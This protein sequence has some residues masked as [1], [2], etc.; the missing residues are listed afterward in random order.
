VDAKDHY[1]RLHS[2]DVTRHA[3]MLADALGLDEGDRRTLAVAGPLHDV[4]KIAMPDRVLRKPTKLTDEEYQIIKTHV[5]Y[6]VAIVRGVLD[7]PAVL[8]VIAHH[9][10]RHDGLGYP[11]GRRGDQTPLLGRI[12]Q[13]AD[14][15]SA[16]SLD[17]PYRRG[18]SPEHVIAELRRGAGTQFD[19]ALVEP[20]IAAY[21]AAVSSAQLYNL[22]SPAR[23]DNSD[24]LCAVAANDHD[25]RLLGHAAR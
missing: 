21:S 2:L 13:I 3:L 25:G 22:P 19:P 16:M 10:E 18:L 20:F 12:M 24:A 7:D 11:Q 8:D 6:G 9:H 23:S 17:R 15:V 5:T 4:G 14:A 1:T